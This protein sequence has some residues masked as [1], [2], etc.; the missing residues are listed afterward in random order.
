[1][2]FVPVDGRFCGKLFR[3]GAPCEDATVLRHEIQRRGKTERKQN[4]L[5]ISSQ[6]SEM[7][8]LVLKSPLSA[9]DPPI[10]HQISRSHS[11]TKVFAHWR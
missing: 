11:S 9:I 6:A 5:E 4:N 3:S 8:V 10:F 2:L 1:M 7:K